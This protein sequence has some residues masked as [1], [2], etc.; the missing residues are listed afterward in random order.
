[1]PN[2]HYS[3]SRGQ[4]IFAAAAIMLALL[5]AGMTWFIVNQP[6]DGG[7]LGVALVGG[8]FALVDHNG[9]RVTEKTFLGKNML[10]VFGFTYC[11][12]VCPTELQVVTAALDSLGARAEAIQPL[13]ITIDPQRD[14]PEIMKQYVA[15]FHP[16]FVGLTGTPEEVAAVA[17]AYRVYYAKVDSKAGANDYL[18]DHSSIMYLMD[19]EG[20]FLKHFSYT[21][22]A[23][24]LADGIA[25]ALAL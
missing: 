2:Q 16:R 1:M 21:T 25:G 24:A 18:M 12:D 7:G 22:D 20:K 11:P 17:R 14:T 4:R 8:P 6:R 23:A 5:I 13:F 19:K 10:V 15:N 9:Q 3:P